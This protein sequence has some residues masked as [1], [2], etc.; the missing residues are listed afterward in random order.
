MGRTLAL[1]GLLA[2]ATFLLP[3]SGANICTAASGCEFWDGNYH[4]YTLYEVDTAQVDVLIVPPASPFATRDS[5]TMR[6]AVEAWDAGIDALGASWFADGL[7]INAYVLG[8]DIPPQAALLDPEII[9]VGAEANPVLLFGIGEQVPASICRARGGALATSPVHSHDGMKIMAAECVDGGIIED[10]TFRLTLSNNAASVT[11]SGTTACLGTV[12]RRNT[13]I[14]LSG[15][16]QV[17]AILFVDSSTGVMAHDNRVACGST[18]L[19]GGVDVGN[20][21]YAA[22]NYVLNTADKS[23]IIDPVADS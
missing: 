11:I 19:A 18:A 4:E 1:A 13:I 10:N 2:T 14:Q 21:G 9:I 23:G 17:S 8:T 15:T 5:E 16:T 20:A 22:E 7:T 3:L 6:K 12:V